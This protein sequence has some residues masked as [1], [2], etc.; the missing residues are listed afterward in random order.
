MADTETAKP[1][2][3]G[4]LTIQE[5][6]PAISSARALQSLRDSGFDLP[7]ALG[8]LIDNSIDANANEID[9]VL[10]EEKNDDGPNRVSRI[11]VADDGMGMDFGTLMGYLVLGFRGDRS[12]E[13]TI[14]KYGVGAKLAAIN[15]AQRIDAWSRTSEEQ[16][17]RHSQLHLDKYFSQLESDGEADEVMVH[18]PDQKP[19]PGKFKEMLPEKTSGTLVV[20]SRIDRLK[21]GQQAANFVEL[22][23]KVVREL[24]RMFRNYLDGGIKITVN[25]RQLM[26]YD[27]LFQMEGHWGDLK[28]NQW[29]EDAEEGTHYHATTF[30]DDT[31][32][33]AGSEARVRVTLYPKE[34][35]RKRGMGGDD[36]AQD[37][38]IPGTEGYISFVRLDREIAFT[39]P[40][41]IFP[42]AVEDGDR[43]IG[44][45]VEFDPELDDFFGVKNVKRG[46]EP[47]DE[48]R[49]AIRENLKSP[50][51]SAR[52]ERTKIWDEAAGPSGDSGD[53]GPED[54][55]EDALKDANRTMPG[56]RAEPTESE[57]DPED[58]LNDL[59]SDVVGDD[60][61]SQIEYIEEI[62]EKGL[63]FIIEPVGWRGQNF[64][65]LNFIKEEGERRVIITIN[66][67]HRFYKEMY[68][69]LFEMAGKDP[70]EITQHEAK[71]TASRAAEALLLMITA[72]AKAESMHEHPHDQYGDLRMHWGQFLHTLMRDVRSVL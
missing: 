11:A 47:Q 12:R 43:F 39:K 31:I 64:I 24:S 51:R 42:S 69:P 70:S 1:S 13:D 72:Y 5:P 29:Y 21:E 45:E 18:P 60:E 27:P 48:L 25:G 10:E 37:L 17:W 6:V 35:L 44:I 16:P 28:V 57:E 46:V 23:S 59:A 30:L 19:V 58:I 56:G 66:T 22:R 40:P 14:G 68:A 33:V 2:D 38:N 55:V 9:I 49:D 52:K 65:D 4:Q 67:R 8:E 32:E 63:P 71:R 20:W 54:S 36:L 34:V 41:Q 61:E 15:F 7:T 3:D 62:R 53:D 26:P 50:V